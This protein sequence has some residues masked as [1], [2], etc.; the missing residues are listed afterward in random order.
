MLKFHPRFNDKETF[1]HTLYSVVFAIEGGFKRVGMDLRVQ[2][3]QYPYGG[4]TCIVVYIDPV[5]LLACPVPTYIRDHLK[6]LINDDQFVSV[7]KLFK[8]N[9][10][11]KRRVP[12]EAAKKVEIYVDRLLSCGAKTN[13]LLALADDIKYAKRTYNF[14]L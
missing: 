8:D 14:K 3:A 5:D 6:E 9:S 2:W 11:I 7:V 1:L 4:D 13:V 10:K 12:T